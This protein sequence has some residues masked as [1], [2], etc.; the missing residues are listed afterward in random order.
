M[1]GVA[2][3]LGKLS[4]EF[5]TGVVREVID[6]IRTAHKTIEADAPSIE[7]DAIANEV[8]NRVLARLMPSLRR[9]IN[10]T[11]VIV[12]TN[13]GR[14]I[15]GAGTIAA[16]SEA[17]RRY[18]D[19]EIDLAAGERGHRDSILEPFLCAL[20]GAEAATVVNNNA[21]ARLGFPM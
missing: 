14:S 12:H 2:E 9:V 10:A 13:L 21:A 11:G 18:C 7:L 16:M 20:T 3:L 6:E 5:V 15:L 1:P 8:E 17:A 19:L 4:D